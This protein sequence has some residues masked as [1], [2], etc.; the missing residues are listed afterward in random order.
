MRLE[1]ICEYNDSQLLYDHKKQT[2]TFE[3]ELEDVA[4]AIYNKFYVKKPSS[5]LSARVEDWAALTSL[6]NSR[7]YLEQSSDGRGMVRYRS[8]TY[9]GDEKIPP[10][11]FLELLNEKLNA[12]IQRHIKIKAFW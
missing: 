2:C 10:P 6:G 1:I 12:V 4:I 9:F 3:G 8:E 11:I 7:L 5:L